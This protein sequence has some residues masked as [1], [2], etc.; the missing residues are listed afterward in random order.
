[1]GRPLTL[2]GGAQ[3]AVRVHDLVKAPAN[4][5]E[6]R[7]RQASWDAT[8]PATVYTTPEMM[9][10]GTPCTAATVILRTKGC[11]WWWSSGCTFCGY[12]NDTRDDVTNEDLHAQW[13]WATRK[14]EGFAG[15]SMVKVYT[16]GSLFEDREIPVEFQQHVLED[17]AKRGLHLIVESR[18]EQLTPEKLAWAASIHSD[19]TVA[20]GLEA[21]DDEVLR[22]HVN[23]G[24]SV[25]SYDKAVAA[26]KD[27][28]IRVKAYLMFKPPFMSEADALDHI[29][30]WIAA[31][32]KDA[33]EISINPMNIQGGTVI[34]RLHRARQYRPP[35]LWSLVE[36]I[37][38]SH[39]VVHPDGGVNG[40]ADQVSRLIVHPTA[41]GRIRGAHNCGSCD[42]DVVAAIERYA[43]SGDLLEF[44]GLSCP[45]EAEWSCELDLERR[46]PVPLGLSAPRRGPPMDRLRAP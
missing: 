26:L 42:A 28:N 6:A 12:F 2:V 34:D 20:I 40:D 14:L 13:A 44:E 33:D 39:V 31:I 29:V 5:P 46:L 38:R 7:R 37:R 16:S 30:T 24:F 4:T 23:K 19:L 22:F 43:V 15:A 41:G 9:P 35:W 8:R 18:T 25:R 10:D 17:C 36:M 11:H 32:A 21:Y 1:M 3:Q 27:A 45:C